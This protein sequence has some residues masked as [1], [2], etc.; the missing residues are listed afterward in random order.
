MGATDAGN[1]G[2]GTPEREDSRPQQLPLTGNGGRSEEAAPE[3]RERETIAHFEPSVPPA[4][5]GP[6]QAAR[7]FVVWSSGP[8]DK[9]PGEN[10]GPEE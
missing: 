2:G 10:R 7:P 5:A 4:A 1:S 3:P 8:A 6:S 9:G